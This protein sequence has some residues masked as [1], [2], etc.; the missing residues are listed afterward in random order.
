MPKLEDHSH[1]ETHNLGLVNLS[2]PNVDSRTRFPDEVRTLNGVN[3]T[4]IHTYSQYTG[5][6]LFLTSS[7]LFSH[8]QHTYIPAHIHTHTNTRPQ[9]HNLLFPLSHIA[10]DS[11]GDATIN[12]LSSY[13]YGEKDY[14]LKCSSNTLIPKLGGQSCG[15]LEL[16]RV[17][18]V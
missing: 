3:I 12:Q 4:Y 2:M 17:L 7:S 13:W 10:K 16:Q 18:K 5:A 8:L 11:S 6:V 14:T 9:K 15:G 1:S